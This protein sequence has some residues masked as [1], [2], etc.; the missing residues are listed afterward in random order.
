MGS[1]DQWMTKKVV[2]CTPDCSVKKAASLM[3]K[4]KIGTVVITGNSRIE[5]IITERDILNFVLQKEF[6]L[7]AKLEKVMTKKPITID[8]KATDALAAYLMQ[9]HKIKKLIVTKND[10]LVGIIT[11][12]DLLKLF[13]E[14]W[15]K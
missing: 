15:V 12:T 4:H 13:S 14:Y 1:I 8:H 3:K 11:Q 10:K 7:N 6:D 5:G 2:T 9:K